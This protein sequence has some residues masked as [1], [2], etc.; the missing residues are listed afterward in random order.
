[1][2]KTIL[3]QSV[4]HQT[5][6]KTYLKQAIQNTDAEFEYVYGEYE[7]TSQIDKIIFLKLFTDLKQKYECTESNSLDIR[8]REIS[9]KGGQDL[10]N[11]RCTIHGIS[12]IKKYCKTNS[13][14]DI[15]TMTFVSKT[16]W[17][18]P[19]IPDVKFYSI[20]NADYNYRINLKKEEEVD[21]LS[22]A[23]T[24]MRNKIN[25]SLKFYRYKKRF[26]FITEDKL[27]RIDLTAVKTNNYEFKKINKAGKT[28]FKKEYKF[29]Q[30]FI[31]SGVLHNGE[32]YE[33]EIEYIGSHNYKGIN[34]IDTFVEKFNTSDP[35]DADKYDVLHKKEH[36]N[37]STIFSE[38]SLCFSNKNL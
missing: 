38:L 5:K 3:N 12:N 9:Y 15:S 14:E 34:P 18:N 20:K 13:I 7:N 29:Y 6:I 24:D 36:T 30:S 26:S 4:G 19:K 28:T 32:T 8:I 1:M 31:E 11:L 17:F 23:A 16:D 35:L 37:G 21:H 27:F 10:S 25:E 33:L 2:S 22:Y